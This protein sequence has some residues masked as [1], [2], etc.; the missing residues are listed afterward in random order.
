MR[1]GLVLDGTDR[2]ELERARQ[3]D[4]LGLWAVAVTG[5]AGTE[6]IRAARVAEA[7]EV[8]RVVVSVDVAAEHPFTVA[9]E[10]AVLDDLAGGRVAV[11]AQGADDRFRTALAGRV[12][13]GVLVSPPPVQT[14]V[15]VWERVARGP[16]EL[17]GRAASAPGRVD[18][19]GDLEADRA[20]VDLGRNEG[21]THLLVVW[22]GDVRV[23]ARHL[24]TRAA[25]ADFPEIVA[26]M[27]DEILPF[28]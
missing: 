13:N 19:T 28:T 3:A 22:P 26:T 23:L 6:A 17:S 16:G 20:T 4:D 15:P 24:V 1:I 8:V 9:E 27:A 5:P 14:E 11:M 12:V 2:A 7:T 18:L 25:S 10:I 21:C